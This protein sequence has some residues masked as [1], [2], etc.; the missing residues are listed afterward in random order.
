MTIFI[1]ADGCPVVNN[2]IRIAKQAGVNCVLVCDTAHVF[3]RV[4]ATTVTVSKGKDSV[5]FVLVNMISAGDIVVTQDYGLAAMCLAR[6][7]VPIR[8]DGLL[9]TTANIDWLL[10][11]RHT[12]KQI[13][14]SGQSARGLSSGLPRHEGSF[15]E[16]LRGVFGV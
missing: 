1:D 10:M 12:A 8:Q 11:Q 3:H 13:R 5:D 6:G 15:E 16:N 9:Y 14:R 7:A 4:G 2:T